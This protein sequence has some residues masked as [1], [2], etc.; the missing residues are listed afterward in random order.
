MEYLSVVFIP[1]VV[2]VLVGVVGYLF[3]VGLKEKT[4]DENAAE[5]KRKYG[6]KSKPKY[7]LQKKPV[8]PATKEKPST[9]KKNKVTFQSPISKEIKKVEPLNT[10]VPN[11]DKIVSIQT[12]CLLFFPLEFYQLSL[13]SYRMEM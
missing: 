7:L 10:A 3:K 9:E 5:Q 4:Y 12:S 8:K 6:T 11:V 13:F 1:I 2:A